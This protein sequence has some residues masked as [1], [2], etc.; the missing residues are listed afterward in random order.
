MKSIQEE[1][2]GIVGGTVQMTCT[3]VYSLYQ[4]SSDDPQISWHRFS[5]PDTSLPGSTITRVRI[6]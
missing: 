6:M 5:D 3:A 1:G 2:Y 4:A